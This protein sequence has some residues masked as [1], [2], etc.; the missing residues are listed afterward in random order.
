MLKEY[1]LQPDLLS[2][3]SVFL[4]LHDKFGYGRGRLIARYP[5]RW[6]K[7]VYDSLSDCLPGTKKRIEVGLIQLKS[8]ICPRLHEWDDKKI[9]LDNAIEEHAKRPFCAII[10]QDNPNSVKAVIQ[11]DHL[12]E[13]GEPRWQAERQ[14]RIER[15]AKEMVACAEPLLRNAR[16]I[17]FVDPYFN[18]QAPRFKRPLQALLRIVAHRPAGIPDIEIHTG[19]TKAGIKSFF[20]EECKKHLPSIIPRG[21]KIRLIRWDQ[22][23]LHN[24]FIL[25]EHGGLKF[26]HG[27]DDHN[28][29]SPKHDIVDLLEP[30]PYK[31]TWQEYQ[32]DSPNFPLI[33]DDL[34]IEGSA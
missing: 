20:D 14:R 9:W 16:R 1:A 23:H 24:R 12:Y 8:A 28:G 26:S 6:E 5:E 11:A 3:L 17:L 32:R 25:T 15:T 30:A 31:A 18:P 19:H 22:D 29:R 13:F 34:I 4:Y 10:S 21:I 33:E 27:L 7:M 2:S